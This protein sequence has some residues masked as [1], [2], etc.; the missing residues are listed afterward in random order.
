[1]TSEGRRDH[2]Q[3][4]STSTT[5]RLSPKF[6]SLP[7]SIHQ[8]CL[9][10][11]LPQLPLELQIFSRKTHSLPVSSEYNY[12]TRE[13]VEE[14]KERGKA[15]GGEASLEVCGMVIPSEKDPMRLLWAPAP[16]KLA[17]HPLTVKSQLFPYHQE[18]VIHQHEADIDELVDSV[19]EPKR[20]LFTR[21]STVS[22]Y[23][24]SSLIIPESLPDVDV[25][26]QS[27]DIEQSHDSYEIYKKIMEEIKWQREQ[28]MESYL[29][30]KE[31]EAKDNELAASASQESGGNT[32]YS[33]SNIS[34]V[35]RAIRQRKAVHTSRHHIKRTNSAIMRSLYVR[36]ELSKVIPPLT[37]T[38]S[39]TFNS[40]IYNQQN[41][42]RGYHSRTN[43]LPSALDFEALM[44]HY[45]GSIN[46]ED[47]YKWS[48]CLWD[49]WFYEVLAE[50]RAAIAEMERGPQ[51]SWSPHV[52]KRMKTDKSSKK[53]KPPITRNKSVI[54]NEVELIEI[55]P[56]SSIDI[57]VMQAK[58]DE[59]TNQ[60][61][62]VETQENKT[63]ELGEL[64]V[65]RSCLYRQIG[66]LNEAL[67][68]IN[69]SLTSCPLL[70]QPH[71]DKHVLLLIQGKEKLAIDEL[72]LL[73]KKDKKHA[74]GFISK[75][76][77]LAKRGH[78]SAAIQSI[79]QAILF[80]PNN[81]QLHFIRGEL[82]EKRGETEGAM[83]DYSVVVK[84]Q[85]NN[86]EALIRQARH[87]FNKHLWVATTQTLT[88]LLAVNH[89][90]TDAWVL[91]SQAYLNMDKHLAA[92][93]DLSAAIHLNP[94]NAL[95]F[96]QRGCLIRK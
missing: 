81:P 6:Q 32:S 44:N 68:D 93:Q 37:R 85:P 24:S 66:R 40:S 90:N 28:L 31:L 42:P 20:R 21:Q 83:S 18:P 12:A 92:L 17:L 2:Y 61:E 55:C 73:L 86:E 36:T 1:L 69:R 88:T 57:E 14:Q 26:I 15:R 22:D 80:E 34:M 52:N 72:T 29:K 71:W 67:D 11:N 50:V 76:M 45:G 9:G 91:R 8:F 56:L 16:P 46:I 35:R 75:G 94:H 64:L 79:S 4:S 89:R 95:L 43:S 33:G 65:Y 39:L 70:V 62:S 19:K 60:I 84:L 5:K 82:R 77:L 25:I 87:K 59:V 51:I 27:N 48:E 30:K 78:I 23:E 47:P 74:L 3:L 54:F 10:H 7:N 38:L 13:K 49:R 41:V 58:L 63:D 96:Y 53:E